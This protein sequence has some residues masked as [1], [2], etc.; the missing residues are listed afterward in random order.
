MY[1]QNSVPPNISS[2]IG[3]YKP[4]SDKDSAPGLTQAKVT[5][6]DNKIHLTFTLYGQNSDFQIS[7]LH[8]TTFEI[9]DRP[10]GPCLDIFVRGFDMERV[11]FQPIDKDTNL[12]GGFKIFG[13]H[14]RGW[15]YFKRDTTDV[16]NWLKIIFNLYTAV[17]RTLASGVKYFW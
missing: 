6:S 17:S 8:N 12:S 5:Y 10:V 16:R 9:W 3:T 1:L 11:Y 13:I 14:P 2:F 7:Y 4:R 15:T